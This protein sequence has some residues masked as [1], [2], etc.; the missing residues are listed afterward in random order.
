MKAAKLKTI[1]VITE[2]HHEDL[3][4]VQELLVDQVVRANRS[5]PAFLAHPGMRGVLGSDSF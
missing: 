3:Q 1:D 2:D 5:S 4:E